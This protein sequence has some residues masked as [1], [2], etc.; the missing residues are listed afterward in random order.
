MTERLHVS[1]K[2]KGSMDIKS[3]IRKRALRLLGHETG[4]D[5]PPAVGWHLNLLE[6]WTDSVESPCLVRG[7]SS[8][9][10]YVCWQFPALS[11]AGQ[12]LHSTSSKDGVQAKT[13]LLSTRQDVEMPIISTHFCVIG[14]PKW[15]DDGEKLG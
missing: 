7:T 4:P 3:G 15:V 12:K 9:I 14:G 1:F 2:N 6:I 10:N 11:T 5:W 13:P 8:R